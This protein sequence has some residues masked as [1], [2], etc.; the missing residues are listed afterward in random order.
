MSSLTASASLAGL[1][2]NFDTKKSGVVSRMGKFRDMT[3]SNVYVLFATHDEHAVYTRKVDDVASSVARLR[4]SHAAHR[5]RFQT[6]RRPR[7]TDRPR[8][9]FDG[10]SIPVF[11]SRMSHFPM[12]N[13]DR[14]RPV[15]LSSPVTFRLA[16]WGETIPAF[17]SQ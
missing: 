2:L 3:N 11:G 17:L 9:R 10:A 13:S 4:T 8:H 12:R 7:S 1:L 5:R 15:E 16:G 14:I 6:H